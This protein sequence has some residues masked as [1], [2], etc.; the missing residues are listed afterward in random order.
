V[1]GIEDA[2]KLH[3]AGPNIMKGYLLPDQP[4]VLVPAR[5]SVFGSGWHDTGDIVNIDEDGFISI[6]GRSKRFAKISGEMISLAAV[7][8]LAISAWPDAQHVVV[9]LPDAKK[10][11]QLIL[12][13]TYPHATA[14]LLAQLSP[15]VAQISL[16]RK[17]FVV[18]K[19]PVLATG[20]TN[21]PQAT[22]LANLLLGNSQLEN[23]D[24]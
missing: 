18:D 6:R 22:E 5:S 14:R 20:K 21:Y 24:E 10:G 8:Q 7:E 3:V 13:S 23:D 15:G 16:P 17:V 1:P 4:G 19:L 12:L 11:E 9:S 2:G